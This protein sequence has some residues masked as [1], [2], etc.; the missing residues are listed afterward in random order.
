[1]SSKPNLPDIQ[2][3]LQSAMS[4][5]FTQARVQ[6]GH[7]IHFKGCNIVITSPDFAGLLPEQRF[8]HVVRAIPADLY[9]SLRSG[10]VWFE[11][12]PGEPAV[13]YM[14]MPRSDDI[15]AHEGEMLKTLAAIKFFKK[16]EA[17]L[18]ES[19]S[20]PS[21]LDFI[22]GKQVLSEAGLSPNEVI[23]ACLFFIKHGG[24]SDAQVFSHVMEELAGAHGEES[25]ATKS[26]K[27]PGAKTTG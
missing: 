6:V 9:E 25:P 13:N 17:K 18:R 21:K 8:H 22:L 12:A 3:K 26:K 4:S 7:D 2:K 1:M 15:S 10:F 27:K 11:L 20:A 16:F 23:R 24:H 5:V 19:K 14:K